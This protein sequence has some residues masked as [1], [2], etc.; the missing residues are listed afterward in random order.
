[1]PVHLP[2]QQ[3]RVERIQRIVRAAPWSEPVRE[4]EEVSL[5]DRVQHLDRR[6]LDDLVFQRGNAQRPLPPVGLGDV[7]SLDRLCPVRPPLQPLREVRE[8]CLEGLAVVPPRLAVRPGRRVPLPREVRHRSPS[9]VRRLR[10]YYRA[11][12]LP[13]VVHH[14]R[15]SLDFPVR[16]LA[17]SARGDHELSRFS[18]EVSPYMRGVSDR[19]GLRSVLRSRHPGYG[20]PLSPTASASR[21]EVLSRLNARPA[22]P[23]VNASRTA[24]HDSGP[25]WVASPSP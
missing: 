19:A 6:A 15:A 2:R 16:P 18:R 8:M 10:S 25:V 12:R 4:A 7:R 21:R 11:V 3:P 5:I 14:R 20:L 9:V 17:P 24:A 22:R 1:H 13:V 23:P